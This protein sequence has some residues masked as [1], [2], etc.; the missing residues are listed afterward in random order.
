MDGSAV[1]VK[2]DGRNVEGSADGIVEGEIVGRGNDINNDES[3]EE[4]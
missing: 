3:Y 4:M 1:G 2:E